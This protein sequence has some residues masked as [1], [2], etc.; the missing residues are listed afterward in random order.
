MF[1]QVINLLKIMF[2][3]MI[4]LKDKHLSIIHNVFKAVHKYKETSIITTI[5]LNIMLA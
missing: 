5:M 3:K 4:V 1:V 2:A